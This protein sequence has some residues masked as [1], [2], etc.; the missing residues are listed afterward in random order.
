MIKQ[1]GMILNNKLKILITARAGSKRI[2]NK[3][4]V[5]FNG[6][7]LILPTFLAAKESSLTQE[8]Y[9]STDC[10]EIS[11][12]A[13]KNNLATLPRPKNLSLDTTSSDEVIAHFIKKICGPED[14]IIL[15]Q[16]TSPLRDH[17]D[18]IKAFN[19]FI[20]YE[21]TVIS[22]FRPIHHPLK[23][24]IFKNNRCAPWGEFLGNER[25]QDLPEL[26]SF[27]G[28]IYIFKVK[29]FMKNS[30]IPKEFTPYIMPYSKSMD[31][32]E[33]NDLEIAEI[34]LNYEF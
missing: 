14:V 32:N 17:H 20:K 8:I 1:N 4:L 16:P 18:V 34:F 13:Q 7:P 19:I 9:V 15:L 31:I 24:V 25:E 30:T 33:V 6:Q 29:D 28:A 22:V 12:L 2:K 26:L 27:N 3:N 10:P 23:S 21:D 5:L 11:R